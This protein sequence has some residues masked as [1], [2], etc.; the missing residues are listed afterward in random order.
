MTAARAIGLDVRP[1]S[2][3]S[4]KIVDQE[5]FCRLYAQ[6]KFLCNIFYADESSLFQKLPRFDFEDVCSFY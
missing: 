1:V 3:F 6:I 2:G 4:N 5:F